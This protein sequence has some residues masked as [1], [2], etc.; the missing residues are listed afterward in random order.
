MHIKLL[1]P[2]LGIKLNIGTIRILSMYDIIDTYLKVFYPNVD[3]EKYFIFVYY[4]LKGLEEGKA[5]GISYDEYIEKELKSTLENIK[6]FGIFLHTYQIYNENCESFKKFVRDFVDELYSHDK[7]LYS[8]QENKYYLKISQEDKEN[9]IKSLNKDELL[10]LPEKKKNRL[11]QKLYE[12]PN[13]IF[14]ADKKEIGIPIEVDPEYKLNQ[15]IVNSLWPLFF[16]VSTE[17]KNEKVV[18]YNLSAYDI[19]TKYL[20]PFLLLKTYFSHL[21]QENKNLIFYISSVILN[22]NNKKLS[23]YRQED[24]KNIDYLLSKY[25]YDIFRFGLTI[26]SWYKDETLKEKYF[27]ESY[28]LKQKIK[29]EII[30]FKKNNL[31][32]INPEKR[33]SNVQELDIILKKSPNYIINDIINKVYQISYQEIPNYKLN[34]NKN[35]ERWYI[36]LIYM[37]KL[38]NY[39]INE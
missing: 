4:S 3:I 10:V 17:P 39:E 27:K 15:R 11:I 34:K 6:K 30:F 23:K 9:A 16:Y 22:Q 24:K 32:N 38:F 35:I 8:L 31:E 26:F 18:Y 5:L 19:E 12:A 29:N 36:F 14:F 21:S 7:I 13:K 37:Y 1:T 2:P 28:K 33:L 25:G 20:I